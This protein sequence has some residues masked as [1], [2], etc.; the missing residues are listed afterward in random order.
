MTIEQALKR[1]EAIDRR[2]S[3]SPISTECWCGTRRRCRPE[4]RRSV[5][6]K[7][8][9]W[10]A[11]STS[12]PPPTRSREPRDACGA[13]AGREEGSSAFDERTGVSSVGTIVLGP[14]RGNWTPISCRSFRNHG[15]SAPDVAAARRTM[16]FR[17]MSR[18]FQDNRDGA[19]EGG[20]FRYSRDPYDPLL[21]V[22][23]P[24]RPRRRSNSCS[25]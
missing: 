22:F 14:A 23:E 16:I 13:E 17:S 4:E 9:C 5:R 1:L 10:N 20:C 11:R 24:G 3:S 21:D 18:C 8:G 15:A 12:S 2:L 19:E 7:W 6:A 25:G